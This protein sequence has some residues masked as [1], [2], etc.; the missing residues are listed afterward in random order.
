MI[1]IK[2][3]VFNNH[4]LVHISYSMLVDEYGESITTV[5]QKI[6]QDLKF[7]NRS[8]VDADNIEIYVDSE[9]YKEVA[10]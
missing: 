9:L 5:D 8:A 4:K 1:K 7:Y 3:K 2:Y 10:L 6:K